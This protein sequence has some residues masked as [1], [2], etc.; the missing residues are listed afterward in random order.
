MRRQMPDGSYKVVNRGQRAAPQAP[1][2]AQAQPK[3][4]TGSST[5]RKLA[6]RRV[7]P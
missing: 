7:L 3:R 6:R 4:G 5:G 1:M 2:A